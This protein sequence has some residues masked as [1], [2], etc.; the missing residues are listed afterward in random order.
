TA[1]GTQTNSVSEI[2]R[3]PGRERMNN[4]ASKAT[5]VVAGA[6]LSVTK[7]D[8]M[9]SVTAGDGITRTY[10][11][12][13]ANA[14]PSPASGVTLT[15]TWPGG[16]T[17]GAITASQGSCTPGSGSFTCSLGTLAA[18]GSATISASYTV[19]ATTAAGTQ[20]NSVS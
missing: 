18:A 5:T 14:G 9:T 4:T 8:G 20:T 13:V 19:P 17:L 12:T 3:A 2:R 6:D 15:D 10:T 1:A 16:F 7:S 11:I